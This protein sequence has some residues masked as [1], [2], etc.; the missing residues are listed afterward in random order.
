M[1]VVADLEKKLAEMQRDC[2]AFPAKQMAGN[3][4][5]VAATKNKK[6]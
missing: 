1:I 3:F 5:G 2:S 4:V 6:M